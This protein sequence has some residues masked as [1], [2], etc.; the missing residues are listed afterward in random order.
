VDCESL[1]Q[2]D[3]PD[4]WVLAILCDF[5]DRTP[6]ELVHVILDRLV[7]AL[8]ETPGRLREYVSMLE[9]LASNRDLDVDIHEELKM[10][11]I[12]FEKLPTYRMGWDKGHEEGKQ[13]GAHDQAVESAKKMIAMKFNAMQIASITG[14]PVADIERLR[15]AKTD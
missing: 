4:A 8:H 10:L 5:Q 1:L 15:T 12:E 7:R 13:E 2:Q 9:I 11:T 14:L 6:R 3:S